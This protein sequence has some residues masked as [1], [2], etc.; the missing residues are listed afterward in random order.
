MATTTQTI[1]VEIDDSQAQRA[2]GGLSRALAALGGIGFV[3]NLA[4][5]FVQIANSATE[6]QNKL[7]FAT[8]SVENADKAFAVLADS[9]RRTGSNLGGTVDLFQK[10]AMSAT[11]TGSSTEALALITERFNQT[12]QISGTS[13]AGAAAAL[14]QF[15]QAMQKG[16]LNG[17][18]FRTIMETNGFLLKVLEEQTGK[19]RTELISMASDGRLSAEILGKALMETSLI[20]ENYGKITQTLPQ[21]LENFNTSV[22]EAVKALDEQLGITKALASA[23]TLMSKN[24]G[25]VIGVLG[26]LTVAAIA[27]TAALVPAAVAMTILT[28]GA[29]LLAA[30]G[31]GAAL[32][33]AAQEAGLLG[34]NTD[35]ATKTQAQLNEEARKGLKITAQR[36]QQALDLDKKLKEQILSLNTASKFT[37]QEGAYRS[38][39]LEVEKA[40]Q[41]KRDEYAK[42]G[43][44]ISAGLEKEYKTAFQTKILEEDRLKTRIFLNDLQQA[45]LA[46]GIAD[47]GQRQVALRLEQYRKGVTEEIFKLNKNRVQ[48]DIESNIQSEI[49]RSLEDDITAAKLAQERL[50]I[51]NLDLR[52]QQAAVDALILKYG[53]LVTDKMK[54]QAAAATK[55]RQETEITN[56]LAQQK[57]L[58][59]ATAAPQTQAE[60]IR[61][62]T[63]TIS[64]LDPR[65]AAEHQFNTEM[66]ALR[67]TNF[68]N[69]AQR[70]QMMER[71]QREHSN[72]L[73]EIAKQQAEAD[74]RLS[75][76]TNQ[77]ILDAVRKSQD[78]IRLM[79]QGGVQAVMGSLD[80]M[81]TIFGQLGQYNK[82]A[83]EAAK[84]F[85]LANAIMNTYLGATKALAMYPPPFNFIAAAAVVASGLAQVAAIRSQ[86]YS[87]RQ[88]G[89]PV[90]G[91]QTYLVG[92]NG[93]ELFTPNTTG[94][95][96]RNSDIGGDGPVNVTFN[97]VANDTS[98]FDDLLLSRR[99]LIRS[100]ISDAMLESGRRG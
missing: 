88:L 95:I 52:E 60:Q 25:V 77:G 72:R 90:M 74:L 69:E 26:G 49:S 48:Q 7:I 44:K 98:G 97:I 19:S 15:A 23:L 93:P 2:L 11:F 42:T 9:A 41:S 47:A 65:L 6:M 85:N 92:E 57:A 40:I 91:G 35:K 3:S 30:A 38:L 45:T 62:A 56:A 32:G 13:G 39:Q 8:G 4:Q 10:L 84:A 46:N 55:I 54:E 64:R 27:L 20:T 100:V 86:Q 83:F 82:R 22:T 28:G 31:V 66:E 81:S 87:G 34:K 50:N 99:G 43:Q 51:T 21:A 73:H 5:Q 24:A 37:Q 80:Q 94:S 63:Q 61:T 14:Y 89:G 67:N 17:D 16:T 18:E 96:T 76:V 59:D 79:Q 78:N 33:Y 70:M 53:N 1:R 71:L 29:V 58:L 36:N 75:G 68:Q 12:L